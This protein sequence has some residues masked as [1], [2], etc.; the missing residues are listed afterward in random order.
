MDAVA[1]G[2]GEPE[3]SDGQQNGT[4]QGRG[5]TSLGRR[6]SASLL[7][8]PLVAP[9]VKDAAHRRD[10]H[11]HGNTDEGQTADTGLPAPALLEDDGERGEAEIQ[12]A[13]DDGHVD[14]G[15]QDDR[16]AEQ[17]D[18]GARHG[19]LHLAA[20]ALLGLAL[21]QL[22]DVDLARLLGEGDCA[23]SQQHGCVR[24]GVNERVDDPEDAGE[25]GRQ[26]LD[27]SPTLGLAKEAASNRSC[28]SRSA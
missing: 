1:V 4:D 25:D 11:A 20:D 24:L 26:A 9:I 10:G 15:E 18:P 14:G 6:H 22:G 21:V 27:P 17:Q 7:R 13:V 23:L 8:R 16:L 28:E 3:Q 2:P 19:H 12:R 5:Q